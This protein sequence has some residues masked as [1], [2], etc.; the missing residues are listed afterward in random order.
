MFNTRDCKEFF[1]QK[2]LL[3][4]TVFVTKGFAVESN[5]AAIKTLDMD[6]SKQE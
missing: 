1:I 3:I 6:P 5:F 2:T 4:T